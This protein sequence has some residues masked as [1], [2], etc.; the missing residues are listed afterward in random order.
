MTMTTE[1]GQTTRNLTEFL[2]YPPARH[3][4]PA[5]PPVHMPVPTV[6]VPV[7]PR[8]YRGAHRRTAPVWAYLLT[9]LGTGLMVSAA[10]ASVVLA[11]WR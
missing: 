7:R 5:L 9:G 4:A 8:R 6:Y 11:A 2:Q 10:A 3:A 1:P